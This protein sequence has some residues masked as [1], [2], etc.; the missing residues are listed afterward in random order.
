MKRSEDV[1][2]ASREANLIKDQTRFFFSNKECESFPCHKT[3]DPDSYNCLFCY[4]PLYCLGSS[5]GG[6]FVYLDGIK[7]CSNCLVTHQKDS[8]AYIIGR[9]SEITKK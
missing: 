3:T 4:C 2:T 9:I 1:E 5:C 7:D 8:Y 6:N